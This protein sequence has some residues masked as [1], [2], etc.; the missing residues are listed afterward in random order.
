MG[1]EANIPPPPRTLRRGASI[2]FNTVK[3][4]NKAGANASLAGV[5]LGGG[6]KKAVCCIFT[7]IQA[8]N[9]AAPHEEESLE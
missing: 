9:D 4:T 3:A 7:L 6:G 8:M 1:E 5:K 2:S